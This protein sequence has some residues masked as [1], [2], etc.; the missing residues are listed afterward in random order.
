[1]YCAVHHHADENE[2]DQQGG[3]SSLRQGFAGRDEKTS[4]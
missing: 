3:R 4:S 1:M 2:A